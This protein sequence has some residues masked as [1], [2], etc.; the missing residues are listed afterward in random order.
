MEGSTEQTDRIVDVP[1]YT[2][3]ELVGGG[4]VQREKGK[5]HRQILAAR[6]GEGRRYS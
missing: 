5:S 3:Q 2:S 6:G 1:L 4:G